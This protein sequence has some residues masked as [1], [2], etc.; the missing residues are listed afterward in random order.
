MKDVMIAFLYFPNDPSHNGAAHQMYVTEH[1]EG[2]LKFY[3]ISSI[4]GKERR[5]YG[6]D[7]SRYA[8]ILP[9]E[10][11]H[12]GFRVPSFIDC[13]KMYQIVIERP[14]DLSTLTQRTLAPELKQRI[15]Y[16]ITEMKKMGKHMIFRINEK[17]FR[18]W[19]PRVC[20]NHNIVSY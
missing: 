9:P 12:N 5:V 1:T 8:V 19:N 2:I 11:R 14:I 3:S 20:Y 4:L 13:S 17:D 18:T 15:E 6:E 16:K 10:H 7:S